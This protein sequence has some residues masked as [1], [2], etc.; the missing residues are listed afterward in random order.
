MNRKFNRFG[1]GGCY[2][3]CRCHKRTRDTGTGEASTELCARCM[4]IEGQR[5]AH[6]DNGFTVAE[7]SAMPVGK[8]CPICHPELE[9]SHA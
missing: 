5:N 2:I 6:S 3:C 7:H 9:V 8:L 1:R 4:E